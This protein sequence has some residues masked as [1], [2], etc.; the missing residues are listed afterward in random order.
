MHAAGGS[1]AVLAIT[2]GVVMVGLVIVGGIA[3]ARRRVDR[4][5][6]DLTIYEPADG[7]AVGSVPGYMPGIRQKAEQHDDTATELVEPPRERSV[8]VDLESHAVRVRRRS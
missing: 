8:G 6:P 4:N 3:V 7:S 2:L 5:A 1:A